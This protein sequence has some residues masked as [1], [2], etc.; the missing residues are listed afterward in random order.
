MIENRQSQGFWN[1]SS[2]IIE[3]NDFPMFVKKFIKYPIIK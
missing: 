3:Y 2:R 1:A